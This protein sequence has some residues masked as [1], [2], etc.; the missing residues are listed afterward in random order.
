MTTKVSFYL[1]LYTCLLT[2]NIF[3]FTCFQIHFKTTSTSTQSF[4]FESIARPT[5]LVVDWISRNIYIFDA[6]SQRI[7][8]VYISPE[9]ILNQA[10][11]V[12][13]GVESVGAMA[14]DP[15]A[16][17]ASPVNKFTVYINRHLKTE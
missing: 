15:L 4:E 2:V 12:S 14:V 13:E 7:D 11:I 10:N 16:G 9:G 1:K 8:L 6:R 17:Y 5:M 3:F